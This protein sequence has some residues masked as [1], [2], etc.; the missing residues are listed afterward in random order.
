MFEE[1]SLNG[2]IP[3]IPLTTVLHCTNN[4]SEASKLGEGEFGPIYKVLMIWSFFTFGIFLCSNLLQNSIRE[5]YRME[6]KL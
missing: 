6:D 2:D 3:M 1:E 5:F 4:F